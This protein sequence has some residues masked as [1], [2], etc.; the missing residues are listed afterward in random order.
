MFIDIRVIFFAK[1]LIVNYRVR[2]LIKHGYL[3]TIRF[4]KLYGQMRRI[5][6]IH[7]DTRTYFFGRTS[8]I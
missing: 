7:F 6:E 2:S 8:F 1:H 3:M 4:V 5:E